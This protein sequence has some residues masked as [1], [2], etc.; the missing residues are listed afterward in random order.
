MAFNGYVN[1]MRCAAT[2]VDAFTATGIN[3][4][5]AIQNGYFV[6]LGD[7][8]NTSGAITEFVYNVTL[9]AASTVGNWLVRTPEVGTTV[10]IQ[11]QDDPRY[12]INEAG[13]PMQLIK[14][15]V[16]DIIEV[17]AETISEAAVK[18]DFYTLVDGM[19][20][21]GTQTAD[22]TCFECLGTYYITFGMNDVTTYVFR[23]VA[24]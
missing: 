1:T 5:T 16:G 4:T 3:A 8:Q 15:I 18:G 17:T 11:I 14:P 24:N 6:A 19:L 20:T 9:A 13:Q 2:D 10:A 7:Y 21:K 12:F 23:C 22:A